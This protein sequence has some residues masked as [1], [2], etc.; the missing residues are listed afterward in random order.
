MSKSE[1]QLVS[2]KGIIT[3]LAL[4]LVFFACFAVYLRPYVPSYKEPFVT[5]FATATAVCLSA[6]FWLCL[7]MFRVILADQRKRARE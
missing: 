6:V 5:V 7:S 4:V 1:G 3:D 2:A